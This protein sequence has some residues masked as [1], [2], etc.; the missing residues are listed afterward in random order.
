MGTSRR[1]PESE[2]RAAL[3]QTLCREV[4][5]RHTARREDSSGRV[6]FV[7]E[8][9]DVRCREEVSLTIEEYEFIRKNARRFVVKPGHVDEE[10]ERLLVLEPGRFVV[11]E[12]FGRAGD[13]VAHLDPRSLDRRSTRLGT[14]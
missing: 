8:C 2:R 7:C 6:E 4:N 13:V 5:E 10:S 1:Q 3:N 11:V 9:S 14:R 12:K